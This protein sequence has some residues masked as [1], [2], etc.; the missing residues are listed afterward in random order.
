ML[1]GEAWTGFTLR[2]IVQREGSKKSIKMR[3]DASRLQGVKCVQSPSCKGPAS[4]RSGLQL[5]GG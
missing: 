4:Q 1:W 5:C 3:L 2:D